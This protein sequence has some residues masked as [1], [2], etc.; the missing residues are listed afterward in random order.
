[1]AVVEYVEVVDF[2][3]EEG[4]GEAPAEEAPAEGDQRGIFDLGYG[5][6]RKMFQREFV[7][8]NFRILQFLKKQFSKTNSKKV[9]QM[10]N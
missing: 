6:V 7:P 3:D 4:G 8:R 9:K 1:M 5:M 2:D 10:T